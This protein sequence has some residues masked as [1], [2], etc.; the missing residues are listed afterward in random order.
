M[1]QET[2]NGVDVIKCFVSVITG[3]SFT[4]IDYWTSLYFLEWAANMG[5]RLFNGICNILAAAAVSPVDTTFWY[6]L[7]INLHTSVHFLIM[8]VHS[9][10]VEEALFMR[11]TW[12]SEICF[13]FIL[14]YIDLLLL[15]YID[16]CKF[17]L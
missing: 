14:L 16:A 6:C 12:V 2:E 8:L 11:H 9:V 4:L 10:K 3:F 5:Y 1:Q 15:F 7:H 17:D 13:Y